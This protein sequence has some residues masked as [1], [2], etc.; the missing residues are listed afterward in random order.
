MPALSGITRRS[1][2][3]AGGLGGLLAADCGIGTTSGPEKIDTSKPIVTV[4]LTAAPGNSVT[5]AN[6]QVPAFNELSEKTRVR[7]EVIPT[8]AQGG[9]DALAARIIAGSDEDLYFRETS[10]NAFKFQGLYRVIDDLTKNDKEATKSAYMDGTWDL[11]GW[12]GKLYG[13]PYGTNSWIMV[14]NKLLFESMGVKPPTDTWTWAEMLEMARKLTSTRGDRPTY[15]VYSAINHWQTI[16]TWLQRGGGGTFDA[17]GNIRVNAAESLESLRWYQELVTKSGAYRT[18]EWNGTAQ[19]PEFRK[20]FL[21]GNVGLLYLGASNR[22]FLVDKVNNTLPVEWDQVEMPVRVAGQNPAHSTPL[23]MNAMWR[24]SKRPEA[25][26]QFLRFLSLQTAQL[27]HI[28]T[29]D[30]PAL[31]SALNS[32]QFISWEGKNNKFLLNRKAA[33]DNRAFP[34]GDPWEAWLGGNKR[35]DPNAGFL[36]HEFMLGNMS[37]NDFIRTAEPM[38]RQLRDKYSKA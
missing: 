17:Q 20:S 37:V 5:R 24:T 35:D 22:Q 21:E 33:P 34:G 3:A 6:L 8:P 4:Y 26:Y 16:D 36:L 27:I 23:Q 31:K 19:N 2:L 28:T 15:G 11:C 25:A 7:A 32:Q 1:I 9:T 13:L 30:I 12:Q 18:V 10:G 14:Y 29:G 38:L